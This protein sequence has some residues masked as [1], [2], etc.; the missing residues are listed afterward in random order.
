[1]GVFRVKL[2]AGSYK[3]QVT[4]RKD[5]VMSI[6]IYL[7]IASADEAWYPTHIN[8][9]ECTA[10]GKL[11]YT[12]DRKGVRTKGVFRGTPVWGYSKLRG[13]F[14]KALQVCNPETN[15]MEN[16]GAVVL[17]AFGNICPKGW[18]T[19]HKDHNPANNAVWNLR[20]VDKSTN[21]KARRAYVKSD[22][23]HAQWLLSQKEKYGVT[24]LCD[25]PV[26]VRREYWKRQKEYLRSLRFP[27]Q[28]VA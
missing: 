15:R 18:E 6:E 12:S 24:K 3:L 21:L 19:D 22:T 11:R 9:L 23:L 28:Q 10:T 27:M 2:I 1:M 20:F 7:A 16:V 8:G 17:R 13:R 5:S 14:I 26:D 4:T 25:V